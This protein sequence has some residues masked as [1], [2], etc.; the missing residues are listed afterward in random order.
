MG[1][2]VRAAAAL[3][4][5]FAIAAEVVADARCHPVPSARVPAAVLGS[6]P[7]ASP[8]PCKDGCVPD[9]Y[10]CSQGV[11]RGPAVLTLGAGLVSAMLP[12]LPAAS[13]TGVHPVP[14][15]PPLD[16]A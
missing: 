12:L 14:Y 16:L 4:V 6:A 10:C 9:C 15:R 7:S 2:A 5:L 8:D 3:L 11:T 1:L 13:P